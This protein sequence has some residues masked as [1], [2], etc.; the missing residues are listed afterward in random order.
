M[1]VVGAGVPF[2]YFY[3]YSSLPRSGGGVV[4]NTLD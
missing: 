3:S 2:G 4:D 1:F